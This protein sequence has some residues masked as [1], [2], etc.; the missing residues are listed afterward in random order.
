MPDAWR[1]DNG[2]RA[3]SSFSGFGAAAAGG[4]WNRA[5][6]HV[7]YASQ[8]L[9]TASLEKFVHLPKPIPATMTFIQFAIAFNG[10]AI[11]RLPIL[12]FA[13]ELARGTGGLG[14]AAVR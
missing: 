9:S 12:E 2:K 8:H 6:R 14:L 11:E 4:R 1:I 3:S 10:V 5:G 7:V 13:C